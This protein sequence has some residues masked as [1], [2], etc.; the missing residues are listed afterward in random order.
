MTIL[1]ELCVLLWLRLI[2]LAKVQTLWSHASATRTMR[3]FFA[4]RGF[5]TIFI[6]GLM[7]VLRTR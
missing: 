5:G 4:L 3:G 1:F 7:S 6:L 2:L